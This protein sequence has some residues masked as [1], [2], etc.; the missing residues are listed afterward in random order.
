MHGSKHT[1]TMFPS[2]LLHQV[3]QFRCAITRVLR[4]IHVNRL[5]TLF[6]PYMVAVRK[7]A[8]DDVRFFMFVS[9]YEHRPLASVSSAQCK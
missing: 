6:T 2:F 8:D 4:P 5:L 9:G 3:G 7:R 1:R